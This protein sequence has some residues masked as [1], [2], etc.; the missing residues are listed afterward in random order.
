[1]GMQQENWVP[2]GGGDPSDK[3]TTSQPSSSQP[4]SSPADTGVDPTLEQTPP[5]SGSG[6][7]TTPPESTSS[8]GT[9][10]QSDTGP[11]PTLEQTPPTAG[12][13]SQT[14]KRKPESSSSRSS[15]SKGS[16]RGVSSSGPGRSSSASTSTSS[17]TEEPVTADS[18]ETSSEGTASTVTGPSQPPVTLDNRGNQVVIDGQGREIPKDTFDTLPANEQRLILDGGLDAW[19]EYHRERTRWAR[20]QPHQRRAEL[21]K[22]VR[23]HGGIMVAIAKTLDADSPISV[24]DIIAAGYDPAEVERV[25]SQLADLSSEEM[26]ALRTRGMTGLKRYWAAQRQDRERAAAL[27]ENSGGVEK[28]IAQAWVQDSVLLRAGYQQED[29]DAFRASVGSL[30]PAA[31]EVVRE[32]GLTALNAR[33][34]EVLSAIEDA[35][36]IG[37]ALAIDAVTIADASLVYP[38]EA[39]PMMEAGRQINAAGGIMQGLASGVISPGTAVLAGYS[40]NDIERVLQGIADMPDE[41]R[42]VLA[43]R[44]WDFYQAEQNSIERRWRAYLDRQPTQGLDAEPEGDPGAYRIDYDDRSRDPTATDSAW[45]ELQSHGVARA[46][47]LDLVSPDTLDAAQLPAEYIREVREWYAG[48]PAQLQDTLAEDQDSF[49]SELS[50]YNARSSP[51]RRDPVGQTTPVTPPAKHDDPRGHGLTFAQ[52]EDG[53][54]LVQIRDGHLKADAFFALPP[55]TQRFLVEHGIEPYRREL[56]GRSAPVTPPRQQ[57]DPVAHAARFGVDSSPAGS[58]TPFIARDPMLDGLETRLATYMATGNLTAGELQGLLLNIGERRMLRQNEGRVLRQIQLLS[59]TQLRSDAP[60]EARGTLAAPTAEQMAAIDAAARDGTLSL[61]LPDSRAGPQHVD[62]ANALI[63]AAGLGVLSREDW[64]RLPEWAAHPALVAAHNAGLLQEQWNNLP[65]SMRDVL[66]P[67][68]VGPDRE[69]A[70][71]ISDLSSAERAV[72]DSPI[73]LVQP[74]IDS[75]PLERVAI[76]PGV[77]EYRIPTSASDRAA[78]IA[79]IEAGQ[80]LTPADLDVLVESQSP[81]ATAAMFADF[82]GELANPTPSARQSAPDV[83]ALIEKSRSG[84]LEPME[85]NSLPRWAVFDILSNRGPLAEELPYLTEPVREYFARTAAINQPTTYEAARR[86][87]ELSRL[88]D[89]PSL[90]LDPGSLDDA[91]IISPQ[92]ARQLRLDPTPDLAPDLRQALGMYSAGRARPNSEAALAEIFTLGSAETQRINSASVANRYFQAAAEVGREYDEKAAEAA[93]RGE[94]LTI[95]KYAYVDHRLGRP[96][97][98]TGR[99]FDAQPTA[100]EAAFN[101]AI[102][103]VPLVN[104]VRYWDDSSWLERGLNVGFDALSLVPAT[105]AASTLR[106]AGLSGLKSARELAVLE[107]R[108]VAEGFVRPDRAIRTVGHTVEPLVSPGRLP[109]SAVEIR[110]STVRLP[111]SELGRQGALEARDVVTAKAIQGVEPITTVAG[112]RVE[113]ATTS[114]QRHTGP[115]SIHTTPDIRAFMEG[116]IVKEGR[117]GGLFFAPTLHS[118]F[119]PSS[120]FGDRIVDGVPGALIIRDPAL[121]SKFRPSGKMFKGTAEIESVL[122]P[123]TRIPPPSQYLHIRDPAGNKVVLAVVGEKFSPTE[124]AKLKLLG[125]RDTLVNIFRKPVNIRSI[126]NYGKLSDDAVRATRGSTNMQ[127]AARGARAAGRIDE[128]G[129]LERQA[130]ASLREAREAA[131]RAGALLNVSATGRIILTHTGDQDVRRVLGHAAAV[132][133]FVEPPVSPVRQDRS[134][135]ASEVG[136]SFRPKTAPPELEREVPGNLTQRQGGAT[137]STRTEPDRLE[138]EREGDRDTELEFVSRLPEY[139]IPAARSRISPAIADQ[140]VTSSPRTGFA[141]NVMTERLRTPEELDGRTFRALEPALTPGRPPTIRIDPVRTPD[142]PR[143]RVDQQQVTT[144]TPDRVPSDRPTTER[145][146]P[147]QPLPEPTT[148]RPPPVKRVLAIPTPPDRITSVPPPFDRVDTTPPPA[149]RIPDAPPPTERIP[150]RPP[151][152]TAMPV[153][154]PPPNRAPDPPPPPPT[155][156]TR[157]Q[158]P[159]RVPPAPPPPT[160]RIPTSRPPTKRDGKRPKERLLSKPPKRRRRKVGKFVEKSAWRQGFGFWVLDHDTGEKKFQLDR[161]AGV[162]NVE[163]PGSASKSY[164]P[165]SFDNDPPTQATLDMAAVEAV[166][167]NTL[168]FRSK[169]GR[170]RRTG[171]RR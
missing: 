116:A 111:A 137:P 115:A 141:L 133:S 55:D 91:R 126:S 25:R 162:P 62:E 23:K 138:R 75:D 168:K 121:L 84:P 163:G 38:P 26:T 6:S 43:E 31:Q 158:P 95:P 98:F 79:K 41:Q 20:L 123:G 139:E 78:V 156:I 13:E 14:D 122:P 11:D 94:L 161:P 77:S 70:T 148:K 96:D 18:P 159:E 33:R 106:R 72:L 90:A 12:S 3:P 37:Q 35:G 17:S 88:L 104:T 169:R 127:E 146:L 8:T 22:A 40:E 39:I 45:E 129:N 102:G 134:L 145:N 76:R 155:R 48:L 4:V 153:R 117:E 92:E 99:V 68:I 164:T 124:I 152:T 81:E 28:V 24:E 101:L 65:Q 154:P 69:L 32:G 112:R 167:G 128:A 105:A 30:P 2:Y 160:I 27:I 51:S 80:T 49:E 82:G 9:S 71:Q 85:W 60:F 34:S 149:R 63:E 130:A 42:Q 170:R 67:R 135:G 44:G 150:G 36:G 83:L 171:K 107:T 113:L 136:E 7:Q 52:A 15:G 110:T 120:A 73:S 151:P 53:T 58:T 132:P 114:L 5:P 103:A 19:D 64:E 89:G 21:K 166:A 16:G 56:A 46:V 74:D 142:A 119:L 118:R 131:T 125:A 10:S 157:L 47:A 108:G 59:S 143:S 109:T 54:T 57:D 97:E 87:P 93:Q 29:I 140:L 147:D 144:S 66:A 165:L 86:D 1:M 100:G 61:S 50:R